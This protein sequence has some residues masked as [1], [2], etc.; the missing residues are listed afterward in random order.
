MEGS[1][2]ELSLLIS[3]LK[4]NNIIK[5]IDHNGIQSATRAKD[6]HLQPLSI[7]SKF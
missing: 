1:T 5:I 3:S 7:K 6:A 4:L 2:W